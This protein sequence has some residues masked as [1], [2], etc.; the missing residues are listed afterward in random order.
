MSEEQRAE[1]EKRIPKAN[2]IVSQ[3]K[4][5][6]MLRRHARKAQ[7]PYSVFLISNTIAIASPKDN[8]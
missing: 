4:Y 5:R 1:L 3:T 8:F 2:F 7:T 6:K